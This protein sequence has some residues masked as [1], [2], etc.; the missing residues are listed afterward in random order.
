MRSL[1]NTKVKAGLE[2]KWVN[3]RKVKESEGFRLATSEDIDSGDVTDRHK[4]LT[5]MVRGDNIVE[6]TPEPIEEEP[7]EPIVVE[8]LVGEEPIVV[9]E[10]VGEEPVVAEVEPEAPIGGTVLITKQTHKQKWL[11]SLGINIG[12]N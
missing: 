2:F 3:R 8:E 9:E 7:E 4:T 10:P 11:S 6:S 12:G 5:L 1:G